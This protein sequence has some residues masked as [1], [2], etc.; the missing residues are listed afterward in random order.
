M[1]AQ[2]QPVRFWRRLVCL[3][4]VL[5]LSLL[6]GCELKRPSPRPTQ[7]GPPTA[8]PTATA[9]P[10][11]PPAATSPGGTVVRIVPAPQQIEGGQ[12]STA[13]IRVENVAGLWGAEIQLQFDPMLL[14]V[15]DADP[16]TEGVQIQT[17]FFPSPDF[18]AEN[19]VDNTAGIISYALTQLAPREPVNG[20]G[21][22]ASI[23]FQAVNQGNSDLTLSVVK[24]ATNQGQPILAISQGSQI[25]VVG[26]ELPSA[27]V[28]PVSSSPI[29]APTLQATPSTPPISGNYYVV[30]RGDTLY[31]IARRY[32][33]S[34][35]ELAAYNNISNIHY[36]YVG[37]V[38][39]IPGTKSALARGDYYVVKRGDTL[40]SIARRYGVSAWQLAS[41]N[42]IRNPN[43][44]YVG[45]VIH[46]PPR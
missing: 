31:S 37:Q 25:V 29:A 26:G 6:T 32:G 46:I 41:Y 9:L 23:T 20:S 7:S 44:I 14:Q 3:G 16:G 18:V 33:V 15:Q 27:A 24:L 10:P 28:S 39:L 2:D 5:V 38:L 11:L 22:L 45:Q 21:Q 17:G 40:Y 19:K 34:V 42:N 36:I 30:Q 4:L 35:W 43:R 12:T 1:A 8:S 13:E